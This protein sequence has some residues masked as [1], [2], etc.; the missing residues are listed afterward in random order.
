MTKLPDIAGRY[1]GAAGKACIDE[2]II[3]ASDRID[4]MTAVEIANAIRKHAAPA[5]VVKSWAMLEAWLML[6]GVAHGRL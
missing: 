2:K 6:Q 3:A 5:E 1:F 4:Q